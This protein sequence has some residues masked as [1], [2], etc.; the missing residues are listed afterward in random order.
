MDPQSLAATGLT[1]QQAEAYALLVE[2]GEIS[3]P[4]AAT[5]LGLTR[6]NA[7][8]LFDKLV[9][10]RLAEKIQKNKKSV[11]R[12]SNPL[13]LAS[14]V[15]EYRA[16]AVAREQAA[17]AIMNNLL[18]AYYKQSEQPAV[19]VVSGRQ[20][21]ANAYRKQISLHEDIYFIHTKADVPIMGF[22]TMHEIRVAPARHG[23]QRHGMLGDVIDGPVNYESHKRSNLDI[24]WVKREDY[25]APVEWSVTESSLMIVL[26]GTEPH[27][28]TIANPIIAGAFL[29]LWH[30]LNSCLRA[31][32]Y[33]SEL[34]RSKHTA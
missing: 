23:L 22:D 27:A 9:E 10:L 5:E 6:T 34:P 21:V 31:M 28:I 13:A 3:P 19:E 29:Q 17:S 24:T 14:Y 25:N 8:K 2:R 7:Y 1:A 33:Y 12:F 16:E 26:Y 11:Y 20:A 32:S 30:L 4:E 18:T 15:S